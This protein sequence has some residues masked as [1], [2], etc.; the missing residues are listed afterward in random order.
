MLA[1]YLLPAFVGCVL[2][3]VLLCF[4]LGALVVLR[5]LYGYV[6]ALWDALLSEA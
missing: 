1:L 3:L 5:R 4:V 2:A 6:R